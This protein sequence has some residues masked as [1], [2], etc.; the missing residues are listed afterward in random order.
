MRLRLRPSCACA[1]ARPAP[2]PITQGLRPSPRAC[3]CAHHP[4]P[5]PAP[6]TQGL[7]PSPRACAC[8]HHPGPAPPGPA[9]K[10]TTQ[11]ALG[12]SESVETERPSAFPF[13][14][15]CAGQHAVDCGAYG[16]MP[17]AFMNSSRLTCA[18]DEKHMAIIVTAARA[19]S[20]FAAG[21]SSSRNPRIRDARIM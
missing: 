11:K 16:V 8:A 18:R 1:C 15:S 21:L 19:C 12:R 17:H 7:R 5:A 9:I 6:I 4:G 13:F 14:L 20:F 2:A 10:S 3:A